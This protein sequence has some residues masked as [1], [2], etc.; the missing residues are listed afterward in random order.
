VPHAVV[1]GVRLYYEEHGSGP[2]ILCIH[3]TS[4]SALAWAKAIPALAGHGRVITYDRRGCHRSERPRPYETTSTEEHADDAEALLR[5]LEATPALVI[6]RS[7]GGN[8]ALDLAL[9]YPRSVRGLALL[10]A[11]P[12]GLSSEADSWEAEV[13]ARMEE[14]VAE[15]GVDAVAEAF[16]REVVGMW[17]ELPAEWRRMMTANG[18]AILAE[19]RGKALAVDATSLAKIQAPALVVSATDSA[20]AFRQVAAA[21]ADAIPGARSVR[22][23]GGHMVD[24]TDPE[25]L[26]F[27]AGVVGAGP[28]P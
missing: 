20:E 5:T 3:G 7:Y 9:R 23:E 19:L 6:G 2:P 27:V 14:V 12:A 25:V 11:I 10:E 24:P 28:H 18:Q 1:N 8:V 26:S 15:R 16:V 22:V 17:E 21:L 13:A 4:S